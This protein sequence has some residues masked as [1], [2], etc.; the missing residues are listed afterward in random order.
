MMAM[1]TTTMILVIW[2]VR[3]LQRLAREEALVRSLASGLYPQFSG[4]VGLSQLLDPSENN[5][6]AFVQLVSV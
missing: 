5:E 1:M 3:H 2:K 6:L 4:C